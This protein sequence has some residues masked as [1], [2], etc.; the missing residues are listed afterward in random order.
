MDDK[1]VVILGRLLKWTE[2]GLEYQA[3]PKH[4]RLI[5]E[6]FGMSEDSKPLNC[7]GEKKEDEEDAEW[8]P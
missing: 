3:D 6:H 4:R 2:E 5:L 7:N 8:E 1:E